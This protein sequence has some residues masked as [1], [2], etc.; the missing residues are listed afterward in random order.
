M[1]PF[2][3]IGV[4]AYNVSPFI[5]KT[6]N[7]VMAQKEKNI[8]IIIINDC[9]TDDTLEICRK[10]TKRD[11][12]VR[13][14]N[15]DKNCGLCKVRDTTIDEAKGEYLLFIDGDDLFPP[16]LVDTMLPKIKE[17]NDIMFFSYIEF[18]DE[19]K[20]A[21]KDGDNKWY[22]VPAEEVE[23]FSQFCMSSF[24]KRENDKKF[25]GIRATS[26]WAKAYNTE[27]L[28]KN[29]LHFPDDLRKSQDII[30]N[31]EVY[32]YCKTACYINKPMY[33]YRIHGD[34]V[35][36]RYNPNIYSISLKILAL[37]KALIKKYYPDDPEMMDFFYT[38]RV[39][40]QLFTCMN[41]NY[42]HKDNP[43]T[44]KER[45]R[46][47]YRFID[48]DPYAYTLRNLDLSKYWAERAYLLSLVQKRDFKKLC[49]MY[50]HKK[51]RV[52][53]FKLGRI[54]KRR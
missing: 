18:T 26:V 25:D 48:S 51:Y 1:K 46:S 49:T 35:C 16:D 38:Y 54:F 6:L 19:N 3:T 21:Y 43:H 33:Y 23:I 24:R 34:S 29:N 11:S 31:S 13:T 41:L 5:A 14:I 42:F 47:F 50:K 27:F 28:K 30:F 44:K 39:V 53:C 4:A 8:E 12:R 9:S 2:V 20:I 32:Q 10:L 52:I 37:S 36:K 15:F 7:S 17:K 45:K 40:M 22:N